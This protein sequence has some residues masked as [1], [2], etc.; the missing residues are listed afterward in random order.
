[1]AVGENLAANPTEEES[2]R[3]TAKILGPSS[4]QQESTIRRFDRNPRKMS[5]KAGLCETCLHGRRI[6][7]ARGSE[8]LLCELSK[9]DPSFPK[10]PGLPVLSCAGYQPRSIP[11]SRA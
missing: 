6:R 5:P 7:S 8:F 2:P 3:S 1:M 11:A 4:G 9:T 10:Y